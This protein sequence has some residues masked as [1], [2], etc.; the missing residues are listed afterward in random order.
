MRRALLLLA[1]LLA[2]VLASCALNPPRIVSITPNREVTDVPTN[3]A[4]TVSFD[5]PMNRASVEQHFQLQPA[6]AGCAG[7]RKC[8]YAWSGN[9]FEFLHP[10]VNF[11]LYTEY[12]V[13]MRAGYADES[14]QQNT[15]DHV[16]R[17]TTEKAPTLSSVDPADGATGVA[18]DR[19]IVLTFDR[20]MRADSVRNTVQLSPDTPFLMRQRPGG[21]GSQYEVVP[22]SVLLPN[23]TYTVTADRPLDVHGNLLATAIQARFKTGTLSLARKIGYLV[24][25][26]GEA[27]VA[28]GIVDPHADAFLQRSTPKQIYSLGPQSQATD[29]LLGFDWSP[30]GRRLAVIDAARDATSGPIQI[31]DV[32]TGTAIRPGISGSDVYWSP[33]GTLVYLKDGVLHRYDLT[34]LADV[35]LTDLSDGR[36]I[37]PVAISPDGKSIAYSTIDAQA[38]D[39]LWIMNI[40]LRTRYRPPGLDDPADHPAWSPNGT[41]LAFRRVTA[42]GSQLSVYDLSATGT[43]A[44]RN[45]GSLDVTGLAWEN[46]NSTLIAATGDGQSA[47]LFRVNIFSAGEAGGLVKVTGVKDAPNGSSPNVPAYDRR[48]AFVTEVDGLPQIFLMNGDGSHPQQLTGWEADYPFTGSAPNWTPTG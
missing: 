27:P 45:V 48:I 30:D 47:N 14:G 23:T 26:P 20:P 39:H 5:R 46:D 15:L 32:A 42:G 21:D 24:G 34:T 10:G 25:Q 40:D 3:E 16:W 13:S 12:T 11:A 9:T 4:I 19:N 31:V 36:V 37:P 8:R 41:K 33:D 43:G 1:C 18:P 28:I 44:Y 38:Q 35:A 29:A 17:F 22:I 6:L 7:S 2:P